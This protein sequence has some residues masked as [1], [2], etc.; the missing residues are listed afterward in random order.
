[1]KVLLLEVPKELR[2]GTYMTVDELA[3]YGDQSVEFLVNERFFYHAGDLTV[4]TRPDSGMDM[5][6]GPSGPGPR[7]DTNDDE[8]MD[9]DDDHMEGKG[10]KSNG[11][12]L[13]ALERDLLEYQFSEEDDGEVDGNLLLMTPSSFM[14]PTREAPASLSPVDP[15]GLALD[16][17]SRHIQKLLYESPR[18]RRI[19]E[20]MRVSFLSTLPE[21]EWERYKSELE[22]KAGVTWNRVIFVERTWDVIRRYGKQSVLK[23]GMN[24]PIMTEVLGKLISSVESYVLTESVTEDSADENQVVRKLPVRR[25]KKGLNRLKGRT[26]GKLVNQ[27]VV[28]KASAVVASLAKVAR[29]SESGQGDGAALDGGEK[30]K[31]NL[32]PP[33]LL[34]DLS[35]TATRSKKSAR[36]LADTKLETEFISRCGSGRL[37][38]YKPDSTMT[39]KGVMWRCSRRV[40]QREGT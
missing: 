33:M 8:Q 16:Y 31:E 40:T 22:R 14:S 25:A 36:T 12:D 3:P 4:T 6:Q 38:N 37:D 26:G 17:R 10:G 29:P 19:N 20:T 13:G 39:L 2:G 23:V 15:I 35:S 5:R 34:A 32:I 21:E 27:K 11:L 28:M 24:Q 18:R 1:M 7:P 9:Q 30:K